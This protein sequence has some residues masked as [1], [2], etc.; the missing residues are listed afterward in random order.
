MDIPFYFNSIKKIAPNKIGIIKCIYS[1]INLKFLNNRNIYFLYLLIS[2]NR[3][4]KIFSFV[5]RYIL[6]SEVLVIV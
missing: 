6:E 2:Y 5:V 3:Y 4:L 1:G